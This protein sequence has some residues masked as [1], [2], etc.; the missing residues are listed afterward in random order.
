M[1]TLQRIDVQILRELLKDGRKSFRDIAKECN[2]VDDVIR[3]RYKE[4]KKADVIVGATIQFNFQKLGYS[5]VA[6]TNLSV[7]SQ[8]FENTLDR[9]GK[10]SNIRSVTPLYNSPFN[11]SAIFTLKELSDLECMKQVLC[12]QNRIT[13]IRTFIWTDVRNIPENIFGNSAE[14]EGYKAFLESTLLRTQ[15]ETPNIDESDMRIIDLLSVNGR[16]PFSNIARQIGS[17]TATVSR[18][19]ERLKNNNLIKVSIQ[20]NPAKVGFQCILAINLSLANPDET[21]EVTNRLS[22][23]TGV[24]Y[25]LKI[26]G[27]YDLSLSALVKDCNDIIEINKQILK[28]PNIKGIEANLRPLPKSWPTPRQ[29]ISTL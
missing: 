7:E 23:I 2:T 27:S 9:L 5:G 11:I 29:Y 8:D 25:I 16:L 12:R 17:S 24:S 15:K 1:K 14:N 4:L 21:N 22:E 3:A 19:Y 18:K 13:S 26:S 20:I 28:I 6:S 10:I